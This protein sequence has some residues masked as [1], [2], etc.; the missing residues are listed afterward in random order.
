MNASIRY[1]FLA[2]SFALVPTLAYSKLDTDSLKVEYAAVI[3]K[4]RQAGST[5]PLRD[6][7]IVCSDKTQAHKTYSMIENAYDLKYIPATES[8]A[9]LESGYS[10]AFVVDN[11]GN[12]SLYF[13]DPYIGVDLFY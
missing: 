4:K 13:V 10:R 5:N 6:S 2:V 11:W 9:Q 12:A 7:T 3:E 8:C 1:I